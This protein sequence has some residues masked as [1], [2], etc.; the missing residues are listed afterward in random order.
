MHAA[1]PRFARKSPRSEQ[2]PERVAID[3]EAIVRVR[4][5]SLRPIDKQC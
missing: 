4:T 3:G 5:A 2:F 1:V